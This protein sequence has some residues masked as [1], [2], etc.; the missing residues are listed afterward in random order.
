MIKAKLADMN[1]GWF[2]GNFKPSAHQTKDV[3]VAFK[4]HTKAEPWPRHYHKEA[5]EINLLTKGKMTIYTEN[6]EGTVGENTPVNPGDIFIIEPGEVAEPHFLEDC[7]MIVIKIP[8]VVG[9]KFE[10]PKL[11]NDIVETP[12][13]IT[14]PLRGTIAMDVEGIQKSQSDS[15]E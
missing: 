6:A 14:R 12:A 10:V 3:E 7:E 8:S 9:D 11:S 2:I 4:K 1:G 13:G 5:V 15:F